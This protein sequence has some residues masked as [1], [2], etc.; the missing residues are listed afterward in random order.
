MLF[1]VG[2]TLSRTVLQLRVTGRL[3]QRAAGVENVAEGFGSPT[4]HVRN[5]REVPFFSAPLGSDFV[6][7]S[8]K[9]K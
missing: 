5:K 8:P 6:E 4:L 1:K 2:G 3:E 7:C 9:H